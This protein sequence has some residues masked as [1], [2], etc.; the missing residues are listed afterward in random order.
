MYLK[1]KGLKSKDRETTKNAEDF[2]QL[3]QESWK[4]DIAS[5]ALTQLHQTKWNA[6]QLLSFTQDIQTLHSHLSENQQRYLDVLKEE[7]SPSNWKDLA[8]VTLVQVILLNRRREGEVSRMPLSVYI[9]RDTS[10]THEDVNLALTS[11]EQ[12]LCKHFVRITIVG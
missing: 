1:S 5:Q 12:K 3:Y 7:A 10:E 2:A 4:V 6:P 11:L 8:K 9:S